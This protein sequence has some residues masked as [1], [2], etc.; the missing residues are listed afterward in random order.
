MTEA[1][2]KIAKIHEAL[3]KIESELIECRKILRGEKL[4]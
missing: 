1:D 3:N 2:L 4:E